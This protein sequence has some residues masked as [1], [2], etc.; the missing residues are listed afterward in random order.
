MLLETGSQ[1]TFYIKY[2]VSNCWLVSATAILIQSGS[3]SRIFNIDLFLILGFKSNGA[4][5]FLRR[6]FSAHSNTTQNIVQTGFLVFVATAR[7]VTIVTI[8][9]T[10]GTK[11]TIATPESIVTIV[12]T[13]SIIAITASTASISVVTTA[14]AKVTTIVTI[15]TTFENVKSETLK[16]WILS[17]MRL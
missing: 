5:A 15:I 2:K 10:V 14:S 9:G 1:K 8:A 3:R 16:M 6:I 13:A 4:V 12:T 7:I 17:K 11:V